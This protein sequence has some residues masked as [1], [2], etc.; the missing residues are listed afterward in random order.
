MKP[1]PDRELGL[2]YARAS[3][4]VRQF[5]EVLLQIRGLKKAQRAAAVY[6]SHPDPVSRSDFA[7]VLHRL[8]AEGERALAQG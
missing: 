3:E 6:R 5:P 4:Q 1:I 7:D 8:L 2:L